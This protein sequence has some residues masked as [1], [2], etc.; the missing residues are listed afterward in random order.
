MKKRIK[1]NLVRLPRK[2]RILWGKIFMY[3]LGTI[4]TCEF[5]DDFILY[6]ELKRWI[7]QSGQFFCKDCNST[8]QHYEN[9]GLWCNKCKGYK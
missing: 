2:F 4:G 6:N 1:N 5:K 7:D 3:M 8:L 9:V